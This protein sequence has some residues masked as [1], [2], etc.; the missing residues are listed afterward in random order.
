M[1]PMSFESPGS[2]SPIRVSLGTQCVAWCL[3]IGACVAGMLNWVAQ[4]DKDLAIVQFLLLVVAPIVWM[5]E[6]RKRPAVPVESF[7]ANSERHARWLA[8]V[9]GLT[10]LVTSWLVGHEMEG[11]PPAYHDEYSYLFQAKTLLSGAFSVP[12]HP[13]RP[14]LF[15]QMHVLNEGRMAS[16]YY[17]GTG[18]WLAPFVALGHPYWGH[19]LASALASVFVFWTGF[20]LGRLRV[21]FVSG[22]ACA[23]SPGIALFGNLLLAHQPA[24][25]GLS[26]FV[27]AFVKWQRT[28]VPRDVFFAG[29]GLSYAMLCRPVTAAGIGL[30]FGIA[31]LYWLLFARENGLSV[32]KTKRTRVLIAM[33]LPIVVGWCVMLAYNHDV[34]G[35][36][37][38]SPYQLYTDIYSPRHVYG[39]N[40]VVRGERKLGPKVIEAYDRWAKN[41]TPELAFENACNRWLCSWIWT[42]DL[43]PQLLSTIVVIGTMR[44]IDRRW[45][46]IA[47]AI[48]S[49]HAFHFPYWYHG[50]MGWHYVFETAPLWCLL[51]GLTT[52]LLFRD[53]Q[54]RGRWLMSSWWSLMLLVSLLGDYF[55]YGAVF[56]RESDIPRIS[57]GVSTIEH[58]RRQYAK[59]NRWLDSNVTK[60]PALVLI[61]A[62][63]DD[64]HVD[65]VVN[66]PQLRDDILRAR[67]RQGVTNNLAIANDFPDRA[68]YLCIPQRETIK[69]LNPASEDRVQS[70]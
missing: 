49:L 67:Y 51:L 65:Y 44:Q 1:A 5:I 41:L 14:E 31:F 35:N 8:I 21:A 13:I 70:K 68:I 28:R 52:D 40:N 4:W 42:F 53:W 16:R 11:L 50:I 37:R 29:I 18:L 30:P 24:L 43:L 9:V 2:L 60:R 58:P 26:L 54:S 20:E 6:R 56:H 66:S 62:D 17:P 48:L 33:G 55:P 59:F 63:P 27:W 3:G 45:L 22:L 64:Q 38:T 32:C 10:S 25:A 23:V 47:F 12:S 69:L 46:L 34:T 15:D 36:F 19:W 39:F 7:P 61:E 57:A